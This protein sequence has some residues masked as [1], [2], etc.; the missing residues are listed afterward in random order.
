MR[1]LFA[2]LKPSWARRHGLGVSARKM[3]KNWSNRAKRGFSYRSSQLI[4]ER[5]YNQYGSTDYHQRYVLP[6]IFAENSYRALHGVHMPLFRPLFEA[7]DPD[8]NVRRSHSLSHLRQ[9]NLNYMAQQRTTLS[10]YMFGVLVLRKI[11]RLPDDIIKFIT[12]YSHPINPIKRPKP[13][14]TSHV[15]RYDMKTLNPDWDN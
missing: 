6:A 13:L 8:L 14:D 11:A 7:S 5:G 1:D 10:P 9:Q 4:G 2:K 15:I 3:V 12:R